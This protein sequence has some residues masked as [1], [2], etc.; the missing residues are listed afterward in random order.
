MFI[1][2]YYEKLKDKYYRRYKLSK[3]SVA[4]AVKDFLL[5]DDPTSFYYDNIVIEF[6][7]E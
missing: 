6:G 1:I 5:H 4:E 2:I 7:W 3:W